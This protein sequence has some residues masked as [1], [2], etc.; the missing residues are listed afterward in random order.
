M[1]PD[2]VVERFAVILCH[3][4]NTLASGNVTKGFAALAIH[5]WMLAVIVERWKGRSPAVNERMRRR[6]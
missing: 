2:G 3:A 5:R 6:V 4:E 1:I